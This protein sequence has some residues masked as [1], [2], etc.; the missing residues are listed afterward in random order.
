LCVERKRQQANFSTIP[1]LYTKL[2]KPSIVP[3]QEQ[4]LFEYRPRIH[5]LVSN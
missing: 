2:T 5:H 4:D 3:I 1:P